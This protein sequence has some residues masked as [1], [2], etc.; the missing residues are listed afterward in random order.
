MEI[1]SFA[2]FL[3]YWQRIHQRTTRLAA[4]IPADSIEWTYAKDKFTL[5]DL[6]RHLA[7]I[8]RWM[9]VE[10]ACGRPSRYRGEGAELAPGYGAV[11]DYRRRL[12]E[13]SVALLGA[14]PDSRLLESCRTP[15]GAELTVWKWLRAMIEHEVHHRGQIYLYLGI[16]GVTT[17]PLYGLTAEQVA[18]R[19]IG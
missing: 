10:A 12:H 9:F 15:A 7:T 16:L 5:G 4:V 1:T 13:E 6:L 14:L 8:E 17:P 18:E 2:T 11:M 19:G 3:P